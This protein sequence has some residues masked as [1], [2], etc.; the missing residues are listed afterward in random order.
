MSVNEFSFDV[1]IGKVVSNNDDGQPDGLSFVYY[2]NDKD[3]FK[4][5]PKKALGSIYQLWRFSRKRP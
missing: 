2:L 5:K 4:K 1:T 3:H